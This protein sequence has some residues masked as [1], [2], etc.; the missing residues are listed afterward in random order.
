MSGGDDPSLSAAITS[1]VARMSK[2]ARVAALAAVGADA[3]VEPFGQTAAGVP[4]QLVTLRLGAMCAQVA[5]YGATLTSVRV[6]DARGA[7]THVVLGFD[8]LAAYEACPFY[9]GSTVGRFANRIRA[10]AFPLE[11]AAGAMRTVTLPHRNDRGNT[12]HGGAAGWDKA[13]WR[14]AGASATACTLEH[15]SPDGDEGFPGAVAI[16]VTY[17]LEWCGRLSIVYRAAVSGAPTVL[18]PTN[19][20]YFNL[21]D[22]GASSV[23]EH[24]LQV[25]ADTFLPTDTACLPTGEL[26][27]VDGAMD[28]R[29]PTPIGRGIG[30]AQ[31][32]NGY[33][34]NYVL[35]QGGSSHTDALDL[36]FAA[37]LRSA[38]TG[39]EMAV[40]TTEPGARL[41]L[42]HI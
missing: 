1:L 23:L 3:H 12:L 11:D 20:A 26:R 39:I 24:D 18:S 34:H 35:A 42:I 6:P 10:G 31:G 28:L 29:E 25:F 37:W 8:E 21:H 2:R 36:R 22:G 14:L 27:P 15:D 17:A 16:S 32:G 19:H 40:L 33:D 38:R 5:T 41:S 4:V 7:P 9:L 13:V 30:A